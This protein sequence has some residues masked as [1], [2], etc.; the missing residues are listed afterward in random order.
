MKQA[1][2]AGWEQSSLMLACQKHVMLSGGVAL[3]VLCVGKTPFK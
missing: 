2:V 1:D 3:Q